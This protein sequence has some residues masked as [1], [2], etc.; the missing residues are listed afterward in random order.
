MSRQ[1]AVCFLLEGL[2][3]ALLRLN[4][5]KLRLRRRFCLRPNA[6]IKRGILGLL[7]KFRLGKRWLGIFLGIATE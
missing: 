3:F 6:R 5:G 2:H 1:D 4:L 7:G